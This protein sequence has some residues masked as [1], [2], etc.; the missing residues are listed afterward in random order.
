MSQIYL[1]SV[2]KW[3]GVN[4]RWVDYMAINTDMLN[5]ALFM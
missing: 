4:H 5:F 2:L 3:A 1:Y